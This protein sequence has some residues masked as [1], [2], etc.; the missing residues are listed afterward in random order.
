MQFEQGG[1]EVGRARELVLE[2]SERY[3]APRRLERKRFGRI[4]EFVVVNVNLNEDKNRQRSFEASGRTRRR[5]EMLTKELTKR[6][7]MG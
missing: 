5:Q 3:E 4:G 2:H 7:L 1:V 6:R